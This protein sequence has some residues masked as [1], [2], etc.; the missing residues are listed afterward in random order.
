MRKPIRRLFMQHRLPVRADGG[1]SLSA[2]TL[3]NRAR[4]RTA[5]PSARHRRDGLH[6]EVGELGFASSVM[7]VVTQAR[8]RESA[9][10][11]AWA[12]GWP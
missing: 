2:S 5:R 10:D 3:I 4:R 7:E 1:R 11:L 6:E 9:S 8:R 12:S